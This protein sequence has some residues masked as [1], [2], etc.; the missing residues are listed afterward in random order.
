M[1]VQ[2]S[3]DEEH[4]MKTLPTFNERENSK[5]KR[6]PFVSAIRKNQMYLRSYTLLQNSEEI[7][8]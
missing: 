4:S 8:Y 7:E 1:H 5:R 3:A 2:S 6:K